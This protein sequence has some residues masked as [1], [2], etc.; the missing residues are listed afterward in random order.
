MEAPTVSSGAVRGERDTSFK[1]EED[2]EESSRVEGE[3]QEGLDN[4]DDP[5][6]ENVS[7]KPDDSKAGGVS[8]GE[9]DGGDDIEVEGEN[10]EDRIKVA[11]EELW[12][13]A[14]LS[15]GK[16]TEAAK[17]MKLKIEG[18]GEWA[19]QDLRSNDVQRER[20]A[21]NLSASSYTQAEP[22]QSDDQELDIQKE[23]TQLQSTVVGT[24]G[25]FGGFIKTAATELNSRIQTGI[26]SDTPA[27]IAHREAVPMPMS[28]F[29]RKVRELQ[30][31][32]DTYC[33]EPE[34]QEA[35]QVFRDN[36]GMS[37]TEDAI[38][39]VFKENPEIEALY[40]RT[41]PALLDREL[42]WSRYFYGLAMLEQE[43]ERRTA[44]LEKSHSQEGEELKWSDTEDVDEESSGHHNPEA[45]VYVEGADTKM[46]S[47][48]HAHQE[49][50]AP[51]IQDESDD[52]DDEDWV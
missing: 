40:S 36:F 1:E 48:S 25:M 35:F 24:L 41:V 4:G 9:G 34:D 21:E 15:L 27:P 10:I 28:R 14:S 52:D 31:N 19:S 12:S 8:S 30:A 16:V 2:Q 49:G 42:F 29:Q 44:L 13:F 7:L 11:A 37:D 47:V 22:S 38:D 5:Q 51:E 17:D 33:H 18:E 3:V 23:I 26:D 43:E 45:A 32:P 20:Q 50:S 39:V 46:A 6:R